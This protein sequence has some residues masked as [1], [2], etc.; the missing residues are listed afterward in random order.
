M[1]LTEINAA[2]EV[3]QLIESSGFRRISSNERNAKQTQDPPSQSKKDPIEPIKILY[4]Q[5]TIF[6][7]FL[8][9]L[10][11]EAILRILQFSVSGYSVINFSSAAKQIN[12]RLSKMCQWPWQYIMLQERDWRNIL[13]TRIQYISFYNSVWLVANDIF[14]GLALSIFILENIGLINQF[15]AYSIRIYGVRSFEETI[16]WLMGWPAGLKLNNFLDK[17]LGELFLW[18]IGSWSSK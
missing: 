18:L 13:A 16:V 2:Y 6:L 3:Q 10:F 7:L 1:K 17:F 8:F 14:F 9:R 15:V 12:Q 5:P 4:Q 11:V